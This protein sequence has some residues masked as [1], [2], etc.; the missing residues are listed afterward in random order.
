MCLKPSY[1]WIKNNQVKEKSEITCEKK[2]EKLLSNFCIYSYKAL[3]SYTD[4]F[5]LVSVIDLEWGI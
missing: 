1:F 4:I 3:Q 2:G 5:K